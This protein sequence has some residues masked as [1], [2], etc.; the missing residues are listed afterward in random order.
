[1]LA[2]LFLCAQFFI[3]LFKKEKSTT[4]G[5]WLPL[6]Q[7]FPFLFYFLS[8]SYS[9]NVAEGANYIGRIT[10]LFFFP[11]LL[12]FNRA[13]ISRALVVKTMRFYAFAATLFVVYIISVLFSSG[14]FSQAI[15]ATDAYYVIRTKIE[16]AS[17]WVHPTYFSFALAIA[18]FAIQNELKNKSLP[19]RQQFW[20]Y[21]YLLVLVTGLFLA[22][23][24]MI[25]TATFLGSFLLW[26]E[27]LNVKKLG[28]SAAIAI[29]LALILVVNIRPVRERAVTFFDALMLEE[30]NEKNPDSMRKAIFT[31]T[32]E[33]I[34]ENFF[35]GT[36]I[37]DQ[38]QALVDKYNAHGFE[39]AERRNLNTHNQYLQ[40]WMSSG[41]VPFIF[42]ILLLVVQFLIALANRNFLYLAFL[43]L[44]SMS[45]L[46]ENI[47]ARQDGIFLFA[48]FNSFFAI[49]SWHKNEKLVFINGRFKHQP[50]TGVQRF[51]EE[52]TIEL[53]QHR[54]KYV[55]LLVH[56]KVAK[57][58]IATQLV[59]FKNGVLWEQLILPFY[60][61]IRGNPLLINFC[62]SAPMLYNNQI[63]TLHDVAFKEH[64]SWFSEN[65][66]RWYNFLIPKIIKRSKHVLTVSRFSKSEIEK[67]YKISPTKITVLYNG[68]PQFAQ[69]KNTEKPIVEGKYALCVGSISERKNQLKLIEAFL[70]MKNPTFTL[71]FAGG[72]NPAVFNNQQHL[73]EQM[74]ASESIVFIQNPTDLA[75]TNLYKFA[76]FTIYVPLYEGFGIPVLESVAF[77]KPVLLSDI[78]VFNELFSEIALF[79]PAHDA[80]KMKEAML[81]LVDSIDLWKHKIEKFDCEKSEYSYAKSAI[82]LNNVVNSIVQKSQLHS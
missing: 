15:S 11:W 58:H 37:G 13:L 76:T 2:V 67:Y 20:A 26:S 28:L 27:K 25:L 18:V 56:K 51:A 4:S 19:K 48:F 82:K 79:T 35:W 22:A 57:T 5:W 50:L 10:V 23:S 12:Y 29:I 32:K 42:F 52:L 72:Y 78:P 9:D 49:A 46:S 39:L 59:A 31:C 74:E 61:K 68:V 3:I 44:A 66:V 6:L 77:G 21:F 64:P 80:D 69:L 65:F 73:I 62:N 81:E 40:I 53:A 7:I 60:L 38:N 30:V 16:V 63:V 47:L 70:K 41:I 17:G 54:G 75:L 24:K 55:V 33:V 71:V 14:T 8:L 45:F 1:M 43:T 36:G 34:A